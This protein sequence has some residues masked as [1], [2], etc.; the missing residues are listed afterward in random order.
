M[1]FEKVI[2]EDEY[3]SFRLGFLLQKLKGP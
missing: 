2:L 1:L 3:P